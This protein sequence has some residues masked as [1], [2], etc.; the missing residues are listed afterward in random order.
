[1]F[2]INR[3]TIDP[4]NGNTQDASITLSEQ[5][6][7]SLGDSLDSRLKHSRQVILVLVQKDGGVAK[8]DLTARKWQVWIRSAT[9]PSNI[10]AFDKKLSQG[11]HSRL[12]TVD[13]AIALVLFPLWG[14]LALFFIWSASSQKARYEVWS[15]HKSASSTFPFPAWINHFAHAAAALWPIF[16]VIAIGIFVVTATSGGLR[17][18]PTYLSRHSFQWAIYQV[19]SN[20]SLPQNINAP[21]FVGV[22]CAILGALITFFLTRYFG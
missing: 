21:V 14:P 18:W 20:F 13:S 10:R 1:M 7:P 8:I 3:S 6:P 2:I 19:R 4:T 5:D 11:A 22:S 15:G 17:V 12:F 16:V 9:V